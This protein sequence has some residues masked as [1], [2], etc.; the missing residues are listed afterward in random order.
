MA[1]KHIGID[2]SKATFN[3]AYLNEQNQWVEKEFKNTPTGRNDLLHWAGKD[4]CFT[5]EATG[6][7]HVQ[8]AIHLH[9][10]A[11][12]VY[13]CNPMLVKRFSQMRL[14][15]AKTDR[16]D[17]RMI[18]EYSRL[19]EDHLRVWEA[20][21]GNLGRSRAM[22]TAI[23]L[24]Q[25]TILQTTNAIEAL[26]QTEAGELAISFLLQTV[27][28]L[29]ARLKEM[30]KQLEVFVCAEH[31][32][33]YKTLQSIP[34]VGPKTSAAL[35]VCTNGFRNFENSKQLCAYV[36]LSPRIFESGSSIRGKGRICKLGN[37]YLRRCLYM[38][39]VASQGCNPVCS[40]YKDGLMERGKA[41]KVALVAVANKLLR[42]IFAI[43]KSGK[44]WNPQE[45]QRS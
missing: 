16:A 25:R 28:S 21:Q 17:A 23:N 37:P 45:V 30:E 41:T 4:T 13:V 12:V 26:S 34:G 9:E 14:Q 43:A 35:I 5:M 10:N 8:T 11:S 15:R 7:Y 22:M 18:A 32:K 1:Q 42:I 27:E 40:A 31:E 29:K 19:N 24:I 33:L 2:I 20:P 6:Y 38:C 36:G 39:A 3:A 44:S